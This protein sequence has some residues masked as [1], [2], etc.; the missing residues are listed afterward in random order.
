MNLILKLA[1]Y[2]L[3]HGDFNEFNLMISDT[4]D[5]TII[6]FPQMVS[7]SHP[8]AEMYFDRDVTCVRVF[9]A[10]R[11]GYEA[12]SYPIFKDCVKVHDLDVL[13]SASGFTKEH[14]KEFDE[15]SKEQ[16]T[17][18]KELGEESREEGE[19][20]EE[21]EED[22]GDEN[23]SEEEKEAT[24]KKVQFEKLH[25]TADV[26]EEG[27]GEGEE[28][29]KIDNRKKKTTAKEE[30][31]PKKGEGKTEED[32][33]N[34]PEAD[35]NGGLEGKGEG[36]GEGEG[37][38]EEHGGKPIDANE[39]AKNVRMKLER[40][41]NKKNINTRKRNVEKSRAKKEIRENVKSY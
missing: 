41:W 32:G 35:A 34:N 37:D 5:I 23:D 10:R 27:E 21:G 6:D 28:I 33:A 31:Q 20:G 4:E 17:V 9:F 25:I 40:K 18:N 30:Q 29:E 3:I 2:G 39:I 12:D 7:T 22:K 19:E 8:N 24:R 13:V 38:G 36:E 14:Q 16:E 26:E 1:S 11:Y 15:L